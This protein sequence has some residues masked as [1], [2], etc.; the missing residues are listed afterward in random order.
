MEYGGEKMD[1]SRQLKN[2]IGTGKLLFGQK[3]AED[4]CARG[5]VKCVIFASNCP[6]DF[7]KSL[8]ARHPEV[9]FH[10]TMMVNRELGVACGKPFSISTV[11]VI[12]SG[13]SELLSLPS[14]IQ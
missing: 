6:Q 9:L 2:A 1:L 4:A 10:Q 12:E 7:M 8:Q 11:S 3:Q 13:N 5:D 14:N